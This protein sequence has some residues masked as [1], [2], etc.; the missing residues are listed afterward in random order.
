M[1]EVEEF[2]LQHYGVK[3]MKWGVRRKRKSSSK[4]SRSERKAAKKLDKQ[5]AK[6]EKDFAKKRTAGKMMNEAVA[7]NSKEVNKLLKKYQV[8]PDATKAEKKDANFKYHMELADMM[9]KHMSKTP[10]ES[11]KGKRYIEIKLIQ[12]KN[13]VGMS[14]N[15]VG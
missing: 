10:I 6:F 13:G 15:L 9:V 14:P 3:G 5:Q 7:A 2:Y 1:N 8:S 4:P 12:T 11:P